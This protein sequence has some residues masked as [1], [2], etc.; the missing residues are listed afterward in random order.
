MPRP[1]STTPTTWGPRS[2]R[3]AL[4]ADLLVEL[5]P[6]PL[7]G[8]LAALLAPHPADLAEEVV[9]VALL[10]G[11]A[12][13]AAGLGPAHLRGVRHPT[14]S[15][16]NRLPWFPVCKPLE[17]VQDPDAY[18]AGHASALPGPARGPRR[19]AE[20][21]PVR[22]GRPRPRPALR[23][24]RARAVPGRRDGP[25]RPAGPHRP[26]RRHRPDH[27]RHP[28]PDPGRGPVRQLGRRRM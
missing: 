5:D 11:L 9:A 12:A 13:L 14:T 24:A 1:R 16:P 26:R 25:R 7:L 23:R 10:G 4:A 28:R 18:A 2:A 6:V 21:G 3:A 19:A 22:Q 20:R 8:R 27:R 17:L 15:F